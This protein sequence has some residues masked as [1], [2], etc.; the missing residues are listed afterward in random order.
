ME[1]LRFGSSI[2]GAYWG[3][4]AMCIIQNFKVDPS[5]KGSIQIVNG[6]GGQP[7]Q[8]PFAPGEKV[9]YNK[10]RGTA[11]IAGTMEEIFRNRLRIGT[12]STTDM[13]N[14]VFLAVLTKSQISGGVGAKWL[15]ILKDEGFEF[16]RTTDNSVYNGANVTDGGTPHENYL[17]GLFRNIGYGNVKDTFTPP[18]EW[19]DLPDVIDEP[20]KYTLKGL[21]AAGSSPSK[22]IND[23]KKIQKKIWD[24]TGPV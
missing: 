5:A 14:H 1:F 22:L 21:E 12:F 2:P 11:F 3:C 13:P 16:I 15:K 19:T 9:D 8:V 6:D 7:M 10:K 20:W 24:R 4:C 17:F 23:T 18:K